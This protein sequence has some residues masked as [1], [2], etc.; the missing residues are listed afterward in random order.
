[1]KVGRGS[2]GPGRRAGEERSQNPRRG[3]EDG[4]EG[5]NKG[6][7]NSV[8]GGAESK[9]PTAEASRARPTD[10]RTSREMEAE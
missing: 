9:P 2:K 3:R 8:A 1:M 4:G 7:G 5:G 10:E 6:A